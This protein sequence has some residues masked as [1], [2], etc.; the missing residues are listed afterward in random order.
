LGF[1]APSVHAAQPDAVLDAMKAELTR[2]MAL[3][4]NQLEKP[5][6]LSYTIDDERTWGASA[7]LGGLL[8]SGESTFRVPNVHIRVG[9]YKFD[10]T[11]WTGAGAAGPRYDLRN[12]PLE[13][14]PQVI[15]QYL[16]L[17]TDSVYKGSLRSIAGK[18]SALR[19]VTVTDQ[20][21]DFARAPKFVSNHDYVPA[22]FDYAAWVERTRKVSAVFDQYPRLRTSSA[23]FTAI[24]ALHRFVTSEDTQVR[25]QQQVGMVEI[26][27]TAQSPD[28]MIVRDLDVFYTRDVGAMFPEAELMKSAQELGAKVQLLADAPLGDSYTGPVLFEGVA[29]AQLMAQLLGRNLHISRKPVAAPG[30]PSQAAV[31]DLEGRRGVRILPEFFDVTDDPTLPLFGHEEVDD[32]GVPDQE[33]SLVEKGV[34]KDFLRTRQ[35]VRGYVESNGHGR[36]SGSYGAEGAVPTNLL[37]RANETSPIAALKKQLIDLCQ[38]RGLPFGMIVRKLD[39]PSS[40]SVDEARRVLA[41]A[42]SSSIPVSMPLYAYRLYL[43]GHEELVRGERFKG[44]NARSLKDILA[45]GD[46][47]VTFNYLENGAPFALL[48]M[49]SSSAQ[50]SIVAPSVLIDDLEMSKIDDE[51]PNLPIVPSPLVS[52]IPGAKTASAR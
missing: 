14:D 3:Q 8:S 2:S 48:G 25:E 5:Y 9:D 29:S 20:L 36:I 13:D 10:N 26:R 33:L 45:A 43:D 51:M 21:P 42:G 32:E 23:Q 41:S 38:Q 15:R 16:W 12:F 50:V 18:V 28:G 49:G 35:P 24:D 40:A 22:K 31:T 11:N 30:A 44:I 47:A 27:A 37:I 34:L 4:L 46:D 1:F 19:N 17:A 39:F 7:T 52:Q 6:Y